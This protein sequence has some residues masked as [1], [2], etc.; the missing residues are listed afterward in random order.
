MWSCMATKEE[1]KE[2]ME[3]MGYDIIQGITSLVLEGIER[4]DL[5]TLTALA[6]EVKA[7]IERLNRR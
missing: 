3:R 5:E 4:D 1:R 7:L 2:G 6:E